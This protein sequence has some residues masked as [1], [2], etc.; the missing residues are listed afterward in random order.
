MRREK[1]D[2]LGFSSFAKDP[3]DTKEE[4]LSHKEGFHDEGA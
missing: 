2:R 1:G 4:R 3:G